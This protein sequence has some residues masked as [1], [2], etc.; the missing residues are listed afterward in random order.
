MKILKINFIL[1]IL[2]VPSLAFDHRFYRELDSYAYLI[3]DLYEFN[4]AS[5]ICII[6]NSTPES[7]FKIFC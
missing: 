3:L 6:Y 5:S 1:S 2:T 4:M 7:E